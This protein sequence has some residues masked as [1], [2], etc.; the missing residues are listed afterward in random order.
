MSEYMC[1]SPHL[2]LPLDDP[3]DLNFGPANLLESQASRFR[4][5]VRPC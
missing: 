1:Y 3:F 4:V 5:A 2:P